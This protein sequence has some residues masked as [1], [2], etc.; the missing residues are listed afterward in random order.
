MI[1]CHSEEWYYVYYD[2]WGRGKKHHV[3]PR[4]NLVQSTWFECSLRRVKQCDSRATWL[5]AVVTVADSKYWSALQSIKWWVL[6]RVGGDTNIMGR[7]GF[8][9]THVFLVF[10]FT[11][12]FIR[13]VAPFLPFPP[14]LPWQCTAALLQLNENQEQHLSFI[15]VSLFLAGIL[16]HAV[17]SITPFSTSDLCDG[18]TPPFS[19]IFTLLLFPGLRRERHHRPVL[20]LHSLIPPFS[21]AHLQ[22]IHTRR[23][24]L[25]RAAWN[26]LLLNG[27]QQ[28]TPACRCFALFIDFHSFCFSACES[29]CACAG[30]AHTRR[31]KAQGRPAH[32]SCWGNDLWIEGMIDLMGEG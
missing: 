25:V 30:G 16:L 20:F 29:D 4:I 8:M 3:H 10:T 24:S 13:F 32:W 17:P 12:L 19:I 2:V 6:A 15:L 26:Y 1:V 27:L 21:G 14:I 9:A 5:A 22:S 18:A 11:L 28:L 23:L 7:C 31:Y